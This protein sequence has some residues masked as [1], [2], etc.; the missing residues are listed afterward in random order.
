LDH[1]N[2]EGMILFASHFDPIINNLETLKFNWNDYY[3]KNIFIF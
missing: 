1:I 2:N 3:K